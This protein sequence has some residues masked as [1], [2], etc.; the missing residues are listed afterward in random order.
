MMEIRA[1]TISDVETLTVSDGFKAA[2]KSYV[3]NTRPEFMRMGEIDGVPVF[4]CG[5]NS[6]WAG[7]GEMWIQIL[8]VKCDMSNVKGENK[9][10]V[11][12]VRAAKRLLDGFVKEHKFHRL[13]AVVRADDK[14]TLRF[15]W[16]LGFD[17]EC[18]MEEYYADKCDAVVL[19]YKTL[20]TECTE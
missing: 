14:K 6:P 20:T 16:W 12:I 8:N 17:V 9:H 7:F 18:V 3:A 19:R 1:F 5:V 15:D 11:S 4:A 2:L 13:Q 10:A